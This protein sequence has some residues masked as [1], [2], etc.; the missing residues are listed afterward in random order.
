MAL[1]WGTVAFLFLAALAIGV[2]GW[3]RPWLKASW[4][5]AGAALSLVWLTWVVQVPQTSVTWT[6]MPEALSPYVHL[7]FTP[8]RW[9][10]ALLVLTASWAGWALAAY[11]ARGVT[12]PG[13]WILWLGFTALALLAVLAA[14]SWAWLWAWA[15]ID[16]AVYGMEVWAA[17]QAREHAAR[18]WAWRAVSGLA[19]WLASFLP[20]GQAYTLW[21]AAVFARAWVMDPPARRGRSPVLLGPGVWIMVF[22][23][24]LSVLPLFQMR[25]PGST[26][27]SA[28]G[29]LGLALVLFA[30]RWLLAPG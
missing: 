29:L 26:S 7:L 18:R 6:W 21:A 1:V 15:L 9:A 4:W 17:P 24:W 11:H 13:A 3:W 27:A 5:V 19:P 28:Y 30:L 14:G 10:L 20:E 23:W 16:S 12:S 22:P 25:I 2:L 8:E